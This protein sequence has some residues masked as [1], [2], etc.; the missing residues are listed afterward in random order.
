LEHPYPYTAGLRFNVDITQPLG[1]RVSN[2]Q[3]RQPDRSWIVFDMTKKYSVITN[4]FTPAGG[5]NY[6]TLKAV[7]ASRQENT[8]LDYADSFL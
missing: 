1:S 4:N 6:N 8:Y 7:P 3:F 2:L 5:D